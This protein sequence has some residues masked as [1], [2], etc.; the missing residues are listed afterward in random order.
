MYGKRR[1]EKEKRRKE[2]KRKERKEERGSGVGQGRARCSVVRWA[3]GCGCGG[4][5][6]S[7]FHLILL[8]CIWFFKPLHRS[9]KSTCS[10]NELDEGFHWFGFCEQSFYVQVA[11]TCFIL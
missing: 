10:G 11:T 2:K 5:I 7:M 8:V 4:V 3:W 9:V 6:C 1:K